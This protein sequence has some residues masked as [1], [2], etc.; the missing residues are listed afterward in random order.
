MLYLLQETLFIKENMMFRFILLLLCL[1][2]HPLFSL[3]QEPQLS[4]ALQ[5][6]ERKFDF[7]E[8]QEQDGIVSHVFLFKNIGRTVVHI[9]GISA[10]CGCV[11]LSL[12]HI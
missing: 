7:G 6:E 2:S 1:S 5:F 11:Q 8:I 10:G 12:I 3:S 9:S 4:E